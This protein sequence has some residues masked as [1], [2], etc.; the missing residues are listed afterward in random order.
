LELVMWDPD[1]YLRYSDERSRPFDDLLARVAAPDPELVVDLGCG[2]GHLTATLAARWPR[3]RITGLDRAPE[4]VTAA[5]A[6][7]PG[8]GFTVGDVRDWTPPPQVGVVVCNAVLH[9]VP[10]HPALLRRWSAAL[11][12]GA[13][14]AVQ[15]PANHAA[16][17]HRAVRAVA[18]DPRWRAEL[19]PLPPPRPVADPADYA[20]LLTEAGCDVDAWETTYLHLL[21]AGEGAGHP[22]LAWLEGTTLR[23]VRSALAADARS[24]AL[25]RAALEAHLAEAYPVRDGLVYFPFRRVFVVA[26]TASPR[27]DR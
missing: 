7:A 24:W 20:A 6:G 26:R 19:G 10:D 22:V 17:S 12:A 15:M 25:F 4:M 8:V 16:A 11:P 27:E 18:D 23:P 1:T 3:A 5:R 21:A 9:W 2:P 14:L 13:W